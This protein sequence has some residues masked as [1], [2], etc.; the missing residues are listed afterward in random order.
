MKIITS[1]GYNNGNLCP[2]MELQDFTS[3]E[4]NA[5]LN[6]G[7]HTQDDVKVQFLPYT[8]ETIKDYLCEKNEEWTWVKAIL[9]LNLFSFVTGQR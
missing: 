6:S 7:N 2:K 3:D 1:T 5:V 9:C 4:F 8:K